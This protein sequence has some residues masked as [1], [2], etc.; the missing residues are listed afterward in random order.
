MNLLL[1]VK[2][3]SGGHECRSPKYELFASNGC[4][5]WE[6]SHPHMIKMTPAKTRGDCVDSVML[7]PLLN[8]ESKNLIQI[9]AK[10]RSSGQV[11]ESLAKIGQIDHLAI[12]T[13]YRFLYINDKKHIDVVAYDDQGNLFSGLEGFRFDW[14]VKS[15]SQ[16]L[17]FIK[18]PEGIKQTKSAD[19]T[20]L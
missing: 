5:S 20:E 13:Q 2:V 9:K 1:P 10:D 7:E 14:T 3:C 8:R 15:G 12:H 4:Y 6:I 18:K 19:G 16:H 11:L 17:K